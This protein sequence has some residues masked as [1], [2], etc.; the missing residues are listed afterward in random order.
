MRELL[1]QNKETSIVQRNAAREVHTEVTNLVIQLQSLPDDLRHSLQVN[2]IQNLLKEQQSDVLAILSDVK[3][4]TAQ[5]VD[6]QEKFAEKG[7]E[8][9]DVIQQNLTIHQQLNQ[10]IHSNV[11]KLT[12]QMKTLPGEIRN[13]L[14]ISEFFDR[15]ARSHLKELHNAFKDHQDELERKIVDNQNKLLSWLTT[16]VNEVVEK[17][18]DNLQE[19]ILGTVVDPLD[20]MGK[21]LNAVTNE[22]PTA[23]NQFGTDLIKSADILAEIPDELE[24]ISKGINGV[25]R[26]TAEASLKPL[27]D[28]MKDFVGT[29]QD[30]HKRLEN[31][32]HGLVNL[33]Q[34][35]IVGIEGR[36]NEKAP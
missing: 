21:K 20:S 13:S 18:I 10:D 3:G 29:V 23:A 1:E 9:L 16:Q 22:M 8:L 15:A 11:E 26:E 31:T 5:V 14:E 36:T 32:I 6:S 24:K 34:K 25:V 17:V 7:G 4:A 12:E 19:K 33:I 30:T 27:S 28:E 2:E 35:L